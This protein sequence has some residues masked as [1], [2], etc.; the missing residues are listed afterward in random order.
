MGQRRLCAVLRT[1][2][3]QPLRAFCIGMV[4]HSWGMGG[5]F[6]LIAREV[7]RV[8]PLCQKEAISVI[9]EH[10]LLKDD[11]DRRFRLPCGGLALRSAQQAHSAFAIDPDNIACRSFGSRG[12]SASD[13]NQEEQTQ[14]SSFHN[15]T[16]FT[17]H[18]TETAADFSSRSWSGS[19]LVFRVRFMGRE[20]P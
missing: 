4:F 5:L 17:R 2:A 8:R 11:R 20:M 12:C 13:Q 9:D 19:C 1:I 3:A 16:S 14:N 18:W 10:T 15:E 7:P 6:Y